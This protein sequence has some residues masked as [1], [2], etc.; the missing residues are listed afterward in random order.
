MDKRELDILAN[1]ISPDD[2]DSIQKYTTLQE[3][4]DSTE[5]PTWMLALLTQRTY[6]EEHPTELVELSCR[7]I[8]NT[9]L[10]GRHSDPVLTI[11]PDKRFAEVL[12][13]ARLYV[14]GTAQEEELI[15]KGRAALDAMK[16]VVQ[17]FLNR[18]GD[19]K[20]LFLSELKYL[21]QQRMAEAVCLTASA[22][23]PVHQVSHA[24]IEAVYD[25]NGTV[26]WPAFLAR[27]EHAHVIRSVIPNVPP[28]Y[29]TDVR[30]TENTVL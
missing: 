16:D 5:S 4:W 21:A 18:I 26:D 19:R 12:R 7:L 30:P 22:M 3:A 17:A 13:V 23:P 10:Y 14:A 20:G 29:D 28:L 27:T 2:Y 9:K 1:L 24:I 25:F 8:E 11:I 15:N 6:R